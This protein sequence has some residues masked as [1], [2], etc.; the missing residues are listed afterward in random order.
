MERNTV[1]AIVAALCVAPSAICNVLPHVQ[2]ITDASGHVN[3]AATGAAAGQAMSVL[4]MAGMPFAVEKFKAVGLKFGCYL[5]AIVLL[6]NNFTKALDVAD[7][8]LNASTSEARTKIAKASALRSDI[9]QYKLDKAAIPAHDIVTADSVSVA[10]TPVSAAQAAR[11]LACRWRANTNCQEKETALEAANAALAKIARERGLTERADVL[12]GKIAAAQKELTDLG[13][14]PKYAD[15]TSAKILRIVAVVYPVGAGAD[16][17]VSEWLSIIWAF[18]I[19]FLAFMGP[20][21][22]WSVSR[23]PPRKGP[24]SRR[25]LRF[26]SRAWKLPDRLDRR[27]RSLM[28]WSRPPTLRRRFQKPKLRVGRRRR[29]R[30]EEEARRQSGAENGKCA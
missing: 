10:R 21:G 1:V 6:C 20:K 25:M 30:A 29:S 28:S 3:S 13:P 11:D 14:L 27:A 15:P 5:L 2:A 19:E 7:A 9:T 23:R 22:L 12:D 8:V 18:G 4:T 16:D 24:R 26:L 17:D